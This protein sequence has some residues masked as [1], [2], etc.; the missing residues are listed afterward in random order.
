MLSSRDAKIIDLWLQKQP[1]LYTR[2]CYH[3]D[4]ERLLKHVKKP[5]ARIT[6]ADLQGFALEL[7]SLGLAPI[8]RA[9][10]LAAIKSLF[11]FCHRM[12]HLPVNPG[13]RVGSAFLRESP[14]PN[15]S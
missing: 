9:R 14:W 3:S 12:R 11:G 15:G 4:S 7:I 13:R 1:S 5:L 8:S 6:L 10:T 2:A